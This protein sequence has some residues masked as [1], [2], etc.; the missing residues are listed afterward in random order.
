MRLKMITTICLIFTL[1]T[2]CF[3]VEQQTAYERRMVVVIASYNNAQWYEGNLSSVFSQDYDNYRV[4]Y[5]NDCSPDGTGELVRNYIRKHGQ[6]NRVTLI[7]NKERKRA[8]CNLYYA[9]ISCDDDE[10]VVLLD[11][12]DKL[13]S[14]GVL[15]HLNNV[16][17]DT[18]VWITF[19]QWIGDPSNSLGYS[20]H[21]PHEVIQNNAIRYH[22]PQ[23]SHLRTFYAKL[24]K[25]INIEDLKY[26]G[27]F[28][29]MTYDLAIMMPM[30]E[31]A[32]FH[33]RF[34]PEILYIYNEANPI[35]DHKVSKELQHKLDLVIRGKK[36]YEKLTH[37]F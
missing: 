34:I 17:A 16:Y 21:I 4:I 3:A 10:I 23:P 8:L 37:L 25:L 11:G 20:R 18:D 29:A 24:F 7:D 13:A 6:E 9:I 19:G 26:E 22:Q 28:F 12:D 27:D 32:G 15:R 35:N 14:P 5:I 36:P 30:M 1:V 33:H 31:M 2:A